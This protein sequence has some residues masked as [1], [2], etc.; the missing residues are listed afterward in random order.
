MPELV[1]N[2]GDRKDQYKEGKLKIPLTMR[3]S[4]S[5]VVDV[6]QYLLL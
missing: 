4:Y 1:N 2:A 5:F 6:G 3:M